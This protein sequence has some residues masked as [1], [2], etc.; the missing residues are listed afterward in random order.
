MHKN[1]VS[2]SWC[3]SDLIHINSF[4]NL[5]WWSSPWGFKPYDWKRHRP[6][7]L[8]VDS[9]NHPFASNMTD[10]KY[11]IERELKVGKQ[12]QVMKA[13]TWFVH[14]RTYRPELECRCAIYHKDGRRNM[15]PWEAG[16]EKLAPECYPWSY[17]DALCA[18]NWWLLTAT[19]VISWKH[20]RC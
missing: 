7:L 9:D 6:K 12:T 3:A 8:I 14:V 11:H 4:L 10:Q 18:D 17:V 15:K 2:T 1:D 13:N 16:L 19:N 20:G 5:L